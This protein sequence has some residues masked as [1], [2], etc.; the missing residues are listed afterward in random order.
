MHLAPTDEQQAVQD[1]ARRF[2]AAEITR[3]RRLEWDRTAE[4]HD[5]AFWAAVADLGWFGFALPGI[6]GRAGGVAPR[7]R[8]ADR[9]VRPRG[10]AVRRVRAP[11]PAASRSTRSA[12]EPQRREW[13]PALAR[14]ERLVSARGRGARRGA[15]AVGLRRR[16]SRGAAT[17]LRLDGEKRF[18]L[19]GVTADAFLV[20]ARDGD[21]VS[22]VLV[23]RDAPPASRVDAQLD[24]RQ[25]PAEH[26]PSRRRVAAVDGALPA[27]PA[28]AWPQLERLRRTLAALLCADLDRRRRCGARDDGARTSASASS[29]A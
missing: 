17:R 8:A 18:V 22:V 28:T 23:P 14:G 15:R 3:E 11:S 21:G 20:A 25:G 5:A 12:R 26:R 7:A 24:A 19:Q 13:L 1:E 10:R 16:C 29:S 6:G 2:L 27:T 9:G 4:G